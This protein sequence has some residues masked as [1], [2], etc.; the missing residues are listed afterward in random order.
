[1]KPW[2]RWVACVGCAGLFLGLAAYP[3]STSAEPEPPP[4]EAKPEAA[5]G[6]PG[7]GAPAGPVP[8]QEA[9]PADSPAASDRDKDL[10]AVLD[11]AAVNRGPRKLFTDPKSAARVFLAALKD[12]DL[13]RLAQ[14]TALRA[15]TAESKNQELFRL[16]L[17]QKLGP[18]DLDELAKRFAGFQIAASNQPANNVVNIVLT[19]PGG[20]LTR[21]L[22]MREEKAGWKV[23]DISGESLIAE[24]ILVPRRDRAD[25][26]Q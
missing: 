13:K 3:W 15:A 16:I 12:K 2:N 18:E 24:P 22:T 5:K 26:R 8:P 7:A 1:M 21:T 17:A 14:A 6:T 19:R 25:D 4:P 10:R 9:P 23:L 11:A 20:I